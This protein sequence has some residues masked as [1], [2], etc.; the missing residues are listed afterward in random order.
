MPLSL[1]W[2]AVRAGPGGEWVPYLEGTRCA[3]PEAS[4][5]V[6]R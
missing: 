2:D 1:R 3:L 5:P 6:A 4:F